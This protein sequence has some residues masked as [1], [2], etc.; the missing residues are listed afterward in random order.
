MASP[1]TAREE[2]SAHVCSVHDQPANSLNLVTMAEGV[3]LSGWEWRREMCGCR[4]YCEGEKLPI[5]VWIERGGKMNDEV[6]GEEND[7]ITG[8]FANK[9]SLPNLFL[10][11]QS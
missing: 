7:K 6:K 2:S 5:I 3:K 9:R 11:C 1:K 8:T 10:S 4:R